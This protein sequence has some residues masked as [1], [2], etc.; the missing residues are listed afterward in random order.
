[1]PRLFS[2][3]LLVS[4]IFLF[5]ACAP[6]SKAPIHVKCPAC[7]YEFDVQPQK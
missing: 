1:M 3:F 5:S 7:A 6:V 4:V 2:F